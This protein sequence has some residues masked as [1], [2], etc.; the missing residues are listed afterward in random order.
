MRLRD[1]FTMN[2]VKS[3]LDM[4]SLMTTSFYDVG[5][6]VVVVTHGG[7]L[8]TSHLIAKGLPC[9]GKVVNASINTFRIS[10]E[11]EWTICSWGDVSHLQA[12]GF[13][14]TGFGGDKLSG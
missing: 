4:S 7:V 14:D 6:R 12:V 13:L 3:L 11:N 9:S 1:F 5:K 10:D 2:Y 8:R